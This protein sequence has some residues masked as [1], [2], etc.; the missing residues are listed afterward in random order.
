MK[1]I[2]GNAKIGKLRTQAEGLGL[3]AT[4]RRRR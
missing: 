4:A 3:Q 1:I 2:G